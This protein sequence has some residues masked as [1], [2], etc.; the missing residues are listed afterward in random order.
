MKWYWRFLRSIRLARGLRKQ[1]WYHYNAQRDLLSPE[2]AEALKKGLEEFDRRAREAKRPAEVVAAADELERIADQ[3]LLPYPFPGIRENI[4][5]FLVSAVFIVA[6]FTFFLQPM[7]IPSGS[8]QPTLW[9]NVIEDFRDDPNWHPPSFFRRILDWFAGIRYYEWIAKDS[10]VFQIEKEKR[11]FIF[12]RCQTMHVGRDSYTLYWP[13]M[14][15]YRKLKVH[16]GQYIR[17]GEPVFKLRIHSGD[18]LFVDKFT[19]HFRRPKRGEIIVFSSH[20]IDR[21][22][23]VYHGMPI[24]VPNTHYI[25]RLIAFGG[26]RVQI[27]DDRHVRINGHRLD[28][29][30]PHFKKIYSFDPNEPPRE[31]HYSGHVN[32]KIAEKYGKHG[33]APLF[34]DENT[35]FVVRRHYYLAFGD[36]TMNSF[37]GRAWGD[38]PRE[39]VVGRAFFVFWPL[40][41]RWGPIEWWE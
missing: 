36:N 7:K 16:P 12:I 17:K 14:N 23:R 21:F 31:N 26:E 33:L 22:L 5:E 38:F 4:K 39:K 1:V 24:L 8:A 29:S 10:G 6:T 25:K 13:P 20:D 30:T 2:A 27:G 41:H 18:R 37:D 19:Y 11:Y 9:G 40:T 35:V 32:E 34:P 3:H 28:A 15:W